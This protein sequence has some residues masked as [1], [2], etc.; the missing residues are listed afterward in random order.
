[1]KV[2]FLNR[3][4]LSSDMGTIIVCFPENLRNKMIITINQLGS[5]KEGQQP[6]Y[7]KCLVNLQCRHCPTGGF[8]WMKTSPRFVQA[9]IIC[10]KFVQMVIKI[11]A[12]FH[13]T[14]HV[15]Q[16]QTERICIGRKLFQNSPQNKLSEL[17]NVDWI[18]LNKK[19]IYIF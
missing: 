3:I 7:P 11:V 15:T 9:K 2:A 18:S 12:G 5:K 4:A 16:R 17:R 6:F 10:E 13:P 1:M 8:R 19:N 14:S